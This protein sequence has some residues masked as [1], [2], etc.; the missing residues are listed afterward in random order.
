MCLRMITYGYLHF[1]F[2]LFCRRVL[3]LAGAALSGAGGHALLDG[4]QQVR[5]SCGHG[6]ALLAGN[7]A[8]VGL[9]SPFGVLGIIVAVRPIGAVLVRLILGTLRIAST[10][11]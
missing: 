1:R 6:R 11:F 4:R 2:G 3:V 9:L 8:P 5:E 7:L 10:L